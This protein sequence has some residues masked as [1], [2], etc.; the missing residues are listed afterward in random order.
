MNGA[1]RI[2]LGLVMPSLMAMAAIW[3]ISGAS[4]PTM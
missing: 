1:G 4:G 3:M 2:P